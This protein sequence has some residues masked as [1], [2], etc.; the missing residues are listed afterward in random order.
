M[1]TIPL[2]TT[3]DLIARYDALFL[4]AY[5]VLVNQ[6][7]QNFGPHPDYGLDK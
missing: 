1:H 2:T 5:G 6:E 4:D 3:A 7:V